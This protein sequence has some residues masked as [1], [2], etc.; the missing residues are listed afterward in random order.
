M[1]WEELN[2][3]ES[4]ECFNNID[5]ENFSYHDVDNKYDFAAK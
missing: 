1:E 5:F 4:E 2:K 3:Q